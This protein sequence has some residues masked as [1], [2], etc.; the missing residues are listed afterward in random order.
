MGILIDGDLYTGQNGTLA[1]SA[2]ILFPDG[3]SP[4]PAA[5]T[6]ASRTAASPEASVLNVI[7]RRQEGLENVS[8]VNASSSIARK[9]PNPKVAGFHPLHRNPAEHGSLQPLNP[10]SSS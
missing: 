10:T 7:F 9:A 1:N 5:T 4:A 3:L 6:A 2:T 8:V